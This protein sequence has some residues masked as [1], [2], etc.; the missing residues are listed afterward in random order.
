MN[1]Q[2]QKI[3]NSKSADEWIAAIRQWIHNE[4]DRKMLQRQLLDGKT[5]EF[6]AEE[7]DLSTVQT[8][9]R[10]KRAREQLFLHM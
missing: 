8:Q 7:N 5:I 6:I 2:H 4:T 3:V 10:L 9:K 1:S